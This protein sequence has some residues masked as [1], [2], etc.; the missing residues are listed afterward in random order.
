MKFSKYKWKW[1]QLLLL[2]PA[3]IAEAK[4]HWEQRKFP[5]RLKYWG[6]NAT[7]YNYIFREFI[8]A[9]AFN[10]HLI[11]FSRILKWERRKINSA[12]KESIHISSA[13]YSW[14]NV[15]FCLRP[16]NILLYHI[17]VKAD[18]SQVQTNVHY[19]GDLFL[20]YVVQ[21]LQNFLQFSQKKYMQIVPL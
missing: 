2:I 8:S 17:A 16:Q 19:L 6:T 11:C 4:P 13:P 14:W 3:W 21:S 9:K 12:S 18:K 10:K 15:I 7:I 5:M 20:R 1:S